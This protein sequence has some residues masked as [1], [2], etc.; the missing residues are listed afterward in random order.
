MRIQGLDFQLKRGAHIT[1]ADLDEMYAL[2]RTFMGVKPGLEAED[3]A[4][5]MSWM[6]DPE[7]FVACSKDAEGRIR[8]FVDSRG[9]LLTVEGQRYLFLAGFYV[10][11]SPE[12]RGHPTYP[13]GMFL[14]Y[15]WLVW[16]HRQISRVYFI[17]A[18][19]PMTFTNMARVFGY[20]SWMVGEKAGSQDDAA[21]LEAA[22]RHLYGGRWVEGERVLN[23][24]SVPPDYVPRNDSARALLARYEAHVPRWREGYGAAGVIPL[25]LATVTASARVVV[26]RLLGR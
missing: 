9:L 16:R 26:R 21:A 3:R 8:V 14:M 2:R 24:R 18:L 25:R 5:F 6:S 12:V 10:F 7:T 1:Q 4:A 22:A 13:L 17:G 11:S 19:Y 15:T 23:M 20:Q